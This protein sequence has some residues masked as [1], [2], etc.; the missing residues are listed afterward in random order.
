MYLHVSCEEEAKSQSHLHVS[1]IL[2]PFFLHTI[3]RRMQGAKAGYSIGSASSYFIFLSLGFDSTGETW[4][5]IWFLSSLLSQFYLK[6]QPTHLE[7]CMDEKS[8]A[9]LFPS[10][11]FHLLV[12]LMKGFTIDCFLTYFISHV[13]IGKDFSSYCSFSS[14][15]K[16]WQ[17]YF[18][19]HLRKKK[20]ITHVL[21][22]GHHLPSV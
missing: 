15:R 19:F 21:N 20:S 10:H 1:L 7:C 8:Q 2:T 4:L 17:S 12:S 18:Y 13:E 22:Q 11:M 14:A 16:I 3:W 5:W 6:Q 9:H